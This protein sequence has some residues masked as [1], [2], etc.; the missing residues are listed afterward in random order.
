[1][2]RTMTH[3]VWSRDILVAEYSVQSEM[4]SVFPVPAS[5]T[6]ETPCQRQM[7]FSAGSVSMES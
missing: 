6:H 2:R 1:M 5:D 7:R 3:S 4:I